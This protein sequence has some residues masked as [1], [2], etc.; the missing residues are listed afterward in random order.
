MNFLFGIAGLLSGLM[1][2]LT[3]IFHIDTSGTV[4]FTDWMQAIGTVGAFAAGVVIFAFDVF[5]RRRAA[6]GAARVA[7]EV[8]LPRFLKVATE[9]HDFGARMDV[10]QWRVEN[11]EDRA[12]LCEKAEKWLQLLPSAEYGPL[13]GAP[14]NRGLTK[15]IP[16]AISGIHT[17]L[18]GNSFPL[19]E[20]DD[21]KTL[22]HQILRMVG[23]TWANISKVT[24]ACHVLR[25]DAID[26]LK[27]GYESAKLSATRWRQSGEV[28]N[29]SAEPMSPN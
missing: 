19:E 16:R 7:A 22:N 18:E 20:G 6:V 4:K 17:L 27:R 21:P 26:N 14:N 1:I 12:E 29:Q 28:D 23:D 13:L 25:Y 2:G 24:A 8:L 15:L 9:I 3:M 10:G 5:Q 11:A